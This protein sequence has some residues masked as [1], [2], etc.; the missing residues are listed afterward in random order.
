MSI[1]IVCQV[2]SRQE[3]TGTI[4]IEEATYSIP[5]TYYPSDQEQQR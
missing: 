4:P 3:I 5:F 2:H 1:E